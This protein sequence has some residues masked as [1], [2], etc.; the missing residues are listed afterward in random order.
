MKR[1]DTSRKRLFFA[2]W[3]ASDVRAAIV[4]ATTSAVAQGA[5]RSTRPDNLH[6]TLVFLGTV[7]NGQVR[8]ITRA[9]QAVGGA[10][11]ELTLTR[12]GYWYRS[13]I[14]WLAPARTPEALAGLA[15]ALADAMRDLGLKLEKRR[16][17]PHVT[18]ARR[19]GPVTHGSIEPIAWAVHEFVLVESRTGAGGSR[20]N[21]I[22][23]FPLA[24]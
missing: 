12:L 16:Y 13:R 10:R 2:L 17:R 24:D 23:R 22:A 18:L 6:I 8:A 11:F 3:P 9:A 4:A 7:E 21:V 15:Q 20:Y 1:V 19:A 5:G 14:V